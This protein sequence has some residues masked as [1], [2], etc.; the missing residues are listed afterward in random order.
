M[1]KSLLGQEPWLHDPLV[2]E[3]PWRD[4]EEKQIQDLIEKKSLSFGIMR[5]DGAITP[6]PPVLRA[7]DTV[8][9]TIERLGH[10]S[11]EWT[12]PPHS[13]GVKIGGTAW[14]YDGGLDIQWVSFKLSP[15]TTIILS[16]L[17][18]DKVILTVSRK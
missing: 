9:K 8:V 18:S 4:S 13:L 10:K 2:H 15:D 6:H 7:V 1:F 14:M 17:V 12:P 16:R 3:I 5:S 11:I